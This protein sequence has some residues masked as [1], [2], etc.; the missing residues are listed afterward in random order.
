MLKMKQRHILLLAAM[1]ATATLSAESQKFA[2]DYHSTREDFRDS[3]MHNTR[4]IY[5]GSH[6]TD[7]PT[8]AAGVINGPDST[9]MNL[10]LRYYYDQF[11]HTQSPDAPYFMFLSRDDRLAMG[12][13]GCVRMRGYYDWGGAVSTSAFAPITIPVPANPENMR[14]IGAT[15]AGTTLYFKVIGSQRIVG[16]YGLYIE[17]NFNGYDG[18]GF[19]LKKA[20]ATFDDWTVGY[21]PSTY[22]DPAALPPT[23]DAQ[24]P[25]NKI[26]PVNVLLRWMPRVHRNWVFAVSAEMP[27]TT[28]RIDNVTTGK[29][30][31]WLPD[32]AAFV[33][34]EW[35]RTSHVRL[36]AIARS[37]N[38]RDLIAAKNHTLCGYGLLLSTVMHPMPAMTFYGTLNYGRGNEGVGTDLLF[39]RYDLL[40]DP[41]RPGRMFMPRSY[42]FCV[43]LQYDIT[44]RV[45]ASVSF[46]KSAL[47]AGRFKQP[48]EYNYGL[49]GAVNLFWN[50]RPRFQAAIEYDW[51]RRKNFSGDA[52]NAQRVGALVQFSF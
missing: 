15:P 19:K 22:S 29:V 33:Q 6:D 26:A 16:S 40:N 43:G 8:T 36:A 27:S 48:D 13:G 5:M 14:K 37:L 10:L 34:Y 41:D 4:I 30:S 42:G 20:Y 50:P 51:G 3:L 12:I 24:G 31:N 44:P 39:G 28:E 17:C 32:G 11:H 9:A 45:F 21:A 47:L 18:V 38:Y 1:A 52:R 2:E 25:S 7:A 35:G 23:V 46:S 49:S